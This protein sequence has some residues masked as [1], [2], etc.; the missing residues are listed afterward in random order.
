MSLARPRF[1][2]GPMPSPRGRTVNQRC[3]R[4]NG[5]IPWETVTVAKLLPRSPAPSLIAVLVLGSALALPVAGQQKQA[6]RALRAKREEP[7]GSLAAVKLFTRTV[8]TQ[9][10]QDW[11]AAVIEWRT[12]LL[13]FPED[14]L[15]EQARNYLGVC[16]MQLKKYDAAATEFARVISASENDAT[17]EEA[18]LNLG[19]CFYSKG[20]EDDR[21]AL[22]KAAKIF[23]AH[24]KTYKDGAYR[25]Q[26]LYFLAESLSMLEQHEKATTYY[27]QLIAEYPD[28]PLR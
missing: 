28:S 27:Q 1:P 3:A 25:D 19:L 22:V 26:S 4:A 8:D 23:D 24:A 13:Q 15:A 7:A 12:F 6:E 16:L 9:N 20:F 18:H 21:K 5:W 11:D 17:A 14:A 10:K 2:S